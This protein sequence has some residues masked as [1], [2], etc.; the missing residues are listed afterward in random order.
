MEEPFYM[1]TSHV[2][3]MANN[4]KGRNVASLVVD[5]SCL[6][7]GGNHHVS[8]QTSEPQHTAP[9]STYGPYLCTLKLIRTD[10]SFS[11]SAMPQPS[12][13]IWLYLPG[14]CRLRSVKIRLEGVISMSF[15]KLHSEEL[16]TVDS[17]SSK[18]KQGH[19]SIHIITANYHSPKRCNLN[20]VRFG[21]NV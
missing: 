6:A 11:C 12:M 13:N 8:S 7:P 10:K 2:P 21:I 5:C 18:S 3:D 19:C 17:S 1:V 4:V 15:P 14:H 20:Y 9:E 16:L